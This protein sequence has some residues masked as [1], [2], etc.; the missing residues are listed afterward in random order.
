MEGSGLVNPLGQMGQAGHMAALPGFQ[1]AL[2][3]ATL[4]QVAVAFLPGR[5]AISLGSRPALALAMLSQL[6]L[7][8]Q[9][10]HSAFHSQFAHPHRV[11]D[12][13]RTLLHSSSILP[14]R[15]LQA[16][17]FSTLRLP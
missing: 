16:L 7:V 15:L 10:T 17:L 2:G 3:Q 12:Y 4:S 11:L 5:T 9:T 13:R 8:A 14:F 1:P 6:V